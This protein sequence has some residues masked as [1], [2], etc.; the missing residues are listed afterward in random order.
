MQRVLEPAGH[1]PLC[2]HQRRRGAGQCERVRVLLG[3]VGRGLLVVQGAAGWWWRGRGLPCS[4][5][6]P[7]QT[8]HAPRQSQPAC[9]C[10]N[11]KLGPCWH[12]SSLINTGNRSLPGWTTLTL[13]PPTPPKVMPLSHPVSTLP[14]SCLWYVPAPQIWDVAKLKRTRTM[15]G[16]RQRVGTQVTRSGHERADV[17]RALECMNCVCQDDAVVV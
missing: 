6:A 17:G 14:A 16:H 9:L 13:V 7:G 4:K 5:V 1:L 15:T 2:R 10:R 11:A 12:Q 3:L 8:T